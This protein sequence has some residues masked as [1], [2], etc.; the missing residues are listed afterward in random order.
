[1]PLLPGD[2]ATDEAALRT[3]VAALKDDPFSTF[4]SGAHGRRRCSSRRSRHRSSR[5]RS[6]YRR[7]S[8]RLPAHRRRSADG[9]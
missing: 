1:V 4:F 3:L 5:R 2:P 8:S 6:S 9:D 7:R